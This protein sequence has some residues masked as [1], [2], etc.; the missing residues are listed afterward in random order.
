MGIKVGKLGA[1]EAQRDRQREMQWTEMKKELIKTNVQWLYCQLWM[2][3]GYKRYAPVVIIQRHSDFTILCL[4]KI[5]IYAFGRCFYLKW[6]TLH[7]RYT[8][9]RFFYSLGI[10]PMTLTLQTTGSNMVL[11]RSLMTILTVERQIQSVSHVNSNFISRDRCF[12]AQ[13]V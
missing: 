11:N 5:Y 9:D 12:L 8:F 7:S 13:V 2:H 6:L 1:L 4:Q 10:E 3:M